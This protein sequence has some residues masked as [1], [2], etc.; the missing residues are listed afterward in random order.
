MQYN[1]H[2]KDNAHVKICLDLAI[3]SSVAMI[4]AGISPAWPCPIPAAFA[5]SRESHDI[6]TIYKTKMNTNG[7]HPQN[8]AW[9]PG[10]HDYIPAQES[11]R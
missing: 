11:Q 10:W 3:I 8:S 7:Y 4:I 6:Y 2:H 1:E 9:L 5:L